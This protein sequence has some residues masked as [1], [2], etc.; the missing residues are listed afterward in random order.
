VTYAVFVMMGLALTV[1]SAP[2]GRYLGVAYEPGLALVAVLIFVVGCGM[3]IGKASVFKYVPDYYPNDVG[4][5]GGL[6]G[7]LGALGGFFLPPA[8]GAVGRATGAPQ[9]AFLVLLVLTLGCLTWLHVVV[10]AIKAR[11]RSPRAVAGVE[12]A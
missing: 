3:G 7:A 6:V 5:V 12:A 1:L 8:F 11:Q 9:A 2:G 4:A 10:L